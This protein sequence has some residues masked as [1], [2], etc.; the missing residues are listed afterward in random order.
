MISET[1]WIDG[2][3][4]EY[5]NTR[6][7]TAQRH[8]D[9]GDT[10]KPAGPQMGNGD[11]RGT[12]NRGSQEPEGAMT[13]KKKCILSHCRLWMAFKISQAQNFHQFMHS[14]SIAGTCFCQ[15][16]EQFSS[17]TDLIMQ[18]NRSSSCIWHSKCHKH[19]QCALSILP[20]IQE[21]NRGQHY[22]SLFDFIIPAAQCL[23]FKDELLERLVGDLQLVVGDDDVEVALLL[24]VLQL[25]GRAG[26][27]LEGKGAT[28]TLSAVL[29]C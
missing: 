2:W 29:Q 16:R 14:I 6:T 5:Q 26:Q 21:S 28:C 12:W 17:V 22:F 27:T 11:Q 25:G 24:P 18:I 13:K 8:K 9:G 10:A 23:L 7:A 20:W 19:S 15:F 4:G 3:S 1:R